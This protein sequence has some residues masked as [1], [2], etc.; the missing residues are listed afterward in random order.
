V[1]GQTFGPDDLQ[2]TAK[3]AEL[4]HGMRHS[5]EGYIVPPMSP[6]T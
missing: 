5:P 4:C 3:I 6:A 1:L 2:F